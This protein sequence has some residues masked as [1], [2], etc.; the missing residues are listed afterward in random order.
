MGFPRQEYWSG[1]P[2]PLPGDFPCPHL[3]SWQADSL[4][5]SH[6]QTPETV[7]TMCENC[8]VMSSIEFS[9]FR[10]VLS[11]KLTWLNVFWWVCERVL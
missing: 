8:Q 9:P 4:P 1:L 3:L 10:F 11:G 2:F 5:L 7:V 6:L